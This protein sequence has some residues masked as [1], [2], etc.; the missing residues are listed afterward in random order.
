MHRQTVVVNFAN[1]QYCHAVCSSLAT[2][3]YLKCKTETETEKNRN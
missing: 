1:L 2:N 3:K